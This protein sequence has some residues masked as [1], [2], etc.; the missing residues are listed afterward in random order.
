MTDVAGTVS[1]SYNAVKLANPVGPPPPSPMTRRQP[2]P[3]QLPQRGHPGGHLR[4]QLPPHGH[5]GQAGS[6]TLTRFAYT[7]TKPGTTTDTALRHSVKDKTNTTTTYTY[8]GLDRLTRS[9]SSL[10][11]VSDDFQYAYDAVGNRTSESVPSLLGGVTTSSFNDAD[12]LT[13]D[14]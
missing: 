1:Y 13:S 12:Q 10:G 5:R 3:D 14:D 2:D 11:L 8:D 6:T 7:Y 9:V 4:R